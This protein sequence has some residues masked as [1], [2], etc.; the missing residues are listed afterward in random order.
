M[1]DPVELDWIASGSTVSIVMRS[2][3]KPADRGEAAPPTLARLGIWVTAQSVP[4][5]SRHQDAFQL[6]RSLR[7]RSRRD[8]PVVTRILPPKLRA[9]ALSEGPCLNRALPHESIPGEDSILRP[10]PRS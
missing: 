4:G 3:K 6:K 8:G 2:N 9:K 10:S 1:L 5:R 7:R